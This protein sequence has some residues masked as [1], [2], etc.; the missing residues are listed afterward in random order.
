MAGD[1]EKATERA[2][3]AGK[4]YK[5]FLK[6]ESKSKFFT[7]S[8]RRQR[9]SS[10][11]DSHVGIFDDYVSTLERRQGLTGLNSDARQLA[12]DIAVEHPRSAIGRRLSGERL[13]RRAGGEEEGNIL[14]E[15]LNGEIDLQ[16][17]A[18][19]NDKQR[20]ANE[21]LNDTVRHEG[22]VQASVA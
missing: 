6:R 3:K 5:E 10:F 2:N 21:E 14:N 7:D 11:L 13:L 22:E 9:R 16:G 17:K 20:I 1:R 18:F 4:I 8:Q 15:N 19:E 12:N